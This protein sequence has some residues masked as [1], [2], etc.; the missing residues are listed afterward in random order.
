MEVLLEKSDAL[1]NA[2]NRAN[3]AET[4]KSDKGWVTVKPSPERLRVTIHT[5]DWSGTYRKK[6][7]RYVLTK[8]H[9]GDTPADLTFARQDRSLIANYLMP[10]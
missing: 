4:L 9:R 10:A 6:G 2:R 1:R 8:P 3:Q 7:A 5:D